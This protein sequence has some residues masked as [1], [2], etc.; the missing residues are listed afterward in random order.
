MDVYGENE[1]QGKYWNEKPG[2]S[3]AAH[4]ASMNER[5]SY[6][7]VKLFAG[8]KKDGCHAGLEIGMV[9]RAIKEA[10]PTSKLLSFIEQAFIQDGI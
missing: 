10:Q 2:Q 4:D 9:F 8:L 1:N 7:S 3:W 6:I 5:L